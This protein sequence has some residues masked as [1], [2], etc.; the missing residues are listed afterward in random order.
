MAADQR[1]KRLNGSSIIGYGD[2]EQHRTK[3]KNLGP[4]Q[5]DLSMKSHIAVEWDTNQKRVVSNP[6]QIG[7]SW[8]H[9]KP[10]A[11]FVPKD[12][13]ILADVFTIPEEIF[14]LDNLSEVLSYEVWKTHLSENEKNFL[15]HFLPSAF[16]PHQT[17][18]ELLSGNKFHF[19]NPFS[20]WQDP[21]FVVFRDII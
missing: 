16:E 11:N 21:F 8:R 12:H 15:M 20:N 7:I 13:S 2:R 14:D 5:N 3:R 4:A 19:S 10:F 18:E 6:E 17:V 9:M 1:R